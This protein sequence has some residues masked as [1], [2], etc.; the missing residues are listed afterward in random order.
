MPNAVT[1]FEQA[2]AEWLGV[3]SAPHDERRRRSEATMK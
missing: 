3:R 2:F 1:R